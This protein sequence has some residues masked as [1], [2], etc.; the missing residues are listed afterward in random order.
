MAVTEASPPGIF[1]QPSKR[2]PLDAPFDL[3][4]PGQSIRTLVVVRELRPECF[5]ITH[6]KFTTLL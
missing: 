1:D 3:A 2:P 6:T 5:A 4:T